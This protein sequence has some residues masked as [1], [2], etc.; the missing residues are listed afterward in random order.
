[1]SSFTHLHVHSHYSV[2]D[3]ASHINKLISRVKELGMDSIALTDHGSMYG[4]KEFHQVALK[5]GIKPIL[6]MESYVARR[7]RHDKEGKKD[8]S[9]YH[10]ILLAKN[11]IGYKNLIKLSSQ[12]FVDGFYYRPRIDRELLE[13]HHEGLIASSACLGGEVAQMIMKQG[14]DAADE[15][16]QW[17]KN[18]FGDDFY[19]EIMLHPANDPTV[20]FDVYENQL[21]VNEAIQ[22]LAIK[23]DVKVIATNDVHFVMEEDAD[24][25]DHL[26]CIT[27]GQ[28]KDDPTRMRY[29]RQE[30]LKS[31]EQMESLFPDFKEA[32]DNTREITDKIEAYELNSAPIMPDF[33]LPEGYDNPADYLRHIS[34]EG[35]FE[36]W[37]NPL[38]VDID[39]RMNFELDTIINMGFPG[40]FLIVADFIAKAREMGVLVGPGRGSAAGSAVAY[41]CKITNIDPIKYDLLFERFLNPDRIS[42]PDID[43]DFDDDGREK[44]L[45]YVV[46]KYGYDHVAHIITFGT[47]AA[48]SSIKDVGRNLNV[49]LP[50]VNSIANLI[51]EGPKVT[52]QKAMKETPELAKLWTDGDDITKEIL[53]HAQNLEG[54]IRQTGVHA[55]GIIISKE[56]LDNYLPICKDSKANLLL[57]Q[58]DGG[59]VEP[60]GMLKMDFLGL[61]T[62]SI[63]KECL[64]YIEQTT[65]DIIDI[66]AIPLDDKATFDLFGKGETTALFQFESAGM[67]KYLKQLQPSVFEDL[68]AMN[69]LYRPGPMAYIPTFCNRKLGK[70]KI[71]YDHPLMEPYLKTTYG[72]TVYQEQVMLLARKLGQFTRGQ[73]DNL[74]KAMGKKIITMMNELKDLFVA[75]CMSNP[76]FIDGCK[77][78]NAEPEKLIHKIWHDWEAFAQ[79]AFNKSHS[80]CYAQIAYQTAYLKA[81]YPSHFM[82]SVLSRNLSDIKKITIFMDEARRMGIEVFGPDVNH[83]YK[84][85]TV[86][87]KGN[88]RFGMAAVKGVGENVVEHLVTLRKE[89]GLFTDIFDFAERVDFRIVTKKNIEALAAGGAFDS[90]N[91]PR[92]AFFPSEGGESAFVDILTKY[93]TT[94][95]D[96]KSNTQAT[97]FGDIKELEIPKPTIPSENTWSKTHQLN[98]ER[99]V[100][101]I[102]L[103]AH[104]L[105][106]FKFEIE[107]FTTADLSKFDNLE[108]FA[109]S[110]V[111]IAGMVTSETIR[112][113]KNNEPWGRYQIEDYT[114]TF[115][116]ALFKD[117]YKN[118]GMLMKQGH[119]VLI[120]GRVEIP[121]WR[122]ESGGTLEFMTKEILM[123]S[124]VREKQVKR[125]T[126]KIAINEVN[127]DLV[128]ELY[129]LTDNV[130]GN[131]SLAFMIEDVDEGIWV[132]LFSQVKKINLD[133]KFMKFVNDYDLKLSI[134]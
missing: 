76:E 64:E 33:P 41:A 103:S 124:E 47:L 73:S 46:E 29:T 38:P 36:R 1:M 114:G 123:L 134:N 105:D 122:R 115:S 15:P 110:D 79:Y 77:V 133:H 14:E 102:Y 49:D 106:D 19:L 71:V 10:L 58:Y 84:K 130:K 44:V 3:G 18:L 104:P 32:L 116:L 87:E 91:V 101:G 113:T 55:C 39:E 25:H 65:G 31:R 82:A 12:A 2:L 35:A 59:F 107:H 48:K 68:V 129:K 17:Y 85:F 80:V 23:H 28:K 50:K 126:I 54:T 63:I 60:V 119:F 20:R 132:S 52:I 8:G 90:F 24:S 5:E 108:D 37:G 78:V 98:Q 96:E 83:S 61:K 97:L 22:R 66:D 27:T 112:L 95:K 93:G 75:G 89:S 70:E 13:K 16:I 67:K 117:N 30:F 74:R 43:I 56:S 100:I 127:E 42:M 94:I 121:R 92:S 128:T 21:K 81:H 9:G 40:Y 62:L 6:G 7:T 131:V 125:V 57:T 26:L 69:A 4:I 11:K 34:M 120:K 51:P 118:F 111:T 86:D 88:V 45:N 72:I 53:L 109:D 99:S